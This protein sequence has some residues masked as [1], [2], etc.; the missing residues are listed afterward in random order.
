MSQG[1]TEAV[2]HIAAEKA[3]G[4][5][6]RRAD[7][8]HGRASAGARRKDGRGCPAHELTWRVSAKGEQPGRE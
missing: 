3:G 7:A 2:D 8:A 1:R 6:N 4:S 5:K